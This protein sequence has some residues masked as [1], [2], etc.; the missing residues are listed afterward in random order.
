[1]PDTG[2]KNPATLANDATYGT[3]AWSNP[4][5]A[6]S[7]NGTYAT[8]N[9][10][11]ET[12]NHLKVTNFTMGVPAGATIN[13]VEFTVEVDAG[14]GDTITDD[15]VMV[16]IGGTVQTG[17][18]KATGVNW[19]SSDTVRTYGGAADLWG[20]AWTEAE[21][22]ASGFGFVVAVTGDGQARIDHTAAKVYYTEA[23]G[24]GG[25]AVKQM[26]YARRRQG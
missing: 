13:G 4:G 18:N 16:V 2:F 26:Y 11:E 12:S 17:H 7:S 22:N 3:I 9:I 20:R 21:V 5:N 14:A 6:A 23:G 8:S 15:R 1:M 10:A 24:G 25:V 19:P